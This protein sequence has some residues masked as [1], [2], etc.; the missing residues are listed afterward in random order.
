VARGLRPLQP[1]TGKSFRSTTKITIARAFN[2]I[3]INF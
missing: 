3:K 1:A 2:S